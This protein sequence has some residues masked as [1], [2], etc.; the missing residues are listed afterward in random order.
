[1]PLSSDS[2]WLLDV[3]CC[4]KLLRLA[5]KSLPQVHLLV[6]LSTKCAH[7]VAV[8]V[9]LHRQVRWEV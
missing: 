6:P 7:P 1:M 9:I 2:R 5:N 3:L 8:L 4:C